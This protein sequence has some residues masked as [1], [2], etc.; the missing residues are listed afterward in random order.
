MIDV[1]KRYIENLIHFTWIWNLM[2]DY[3]SR[4]ECQSKLIPAIISWWYHCLDSY[5]YTFRIA[6]YSSTTNTN[7]RP[8]ATMIANLCQYNFEHTLTQRFSNIHISSPTFFSPV[9]R[10]DTGF[11]NVY[12]N[13]GIAISKKLLQHIQLAIQVISIFDF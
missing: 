8:F 1:G 4:N 9:L 6:G 5:G 10:H 13:T 2:D 11:G 7:I 3:R 12:V